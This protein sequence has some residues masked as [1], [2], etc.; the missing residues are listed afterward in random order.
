MILRDTGVCLLLFIA[1]I[2]MPTTAFCGY[3]VDHSSGFPNVSY[4]YVNGEVDSAYAECERFRAAHE[5]PLAPPQSECK[6]FPTGA[7]A[8]GFATRTFCTTVK[9][10]WG[11]WQCD[12]TVGIKHAVFVANLC[13][14]GSGYSQV[15][16]GCVPI[17]LDWKD[18]PQHCPKIG[19]P[20]S[21]LQ[22]SK[23]LSQDLGIS[24]DNLAL[25]IIYNTRSLQAITPSNPSEPSA[26]F[27][28]SIK[29]DSV[30]GAGW[31]INSHATIQWSTQ[32]AAIDSGDGYLQFFSVTSSGLKPSLKTDPTSPCGQYCNE[33]IHR[34]TEGAYEAYNVS[35]G[36]ERYAIR[37]KVFSNGRSLNYFYSTSS[38][39]SSV[40]P[41]PNLL[42]RVVDTFGRTISFTYQKIGADIRLASIMGP[43]GGKVL[44]GYDSTA[45]LISITRPDMSVRSFLYEQEALPGFLTGVVDENGGRYAS[46]SYDESTGNAISTMLGDGKSRFSVGYQSGP[47]WESSDVYDPAAS[48]IRRTIALKP[49]EGVL[50]TYPSGRVET[51]ISATA[52]GVLKLGLQTQ[53]PGAGCA[54]SSAESGYD[55]NGFLSWTES[56]RKYRTCFSYDSASKLENIRVEGLPSNTDCSGVLAPNSPLPAGARKITTERDSRSGL[57]TRI[58]EPK[59]VTTLVY[60][61]KRD[62]LGTPYSY[63]CAPTNATQPN[64]D[65]I[66]VLCIKREQVTLD[67]DGRAGPAALLDGAALMRVNNWTYNE[68]GQVLS[69]SDALNNATTYTYHPSNT[70]NFARGDLATVKNALN[71]VTSFTK[72]SQSGQWLEMID[73]NG[74]TTTRTFDLRQRLRTT[75]TAGLTTQY[76]YWPTGLLKTVT[77]PDASAVNYGYDDAHRLTSVTDNRGN[78]ITYTLDNSGN[79]IGEAIT[80][81]SGRLAKTL[82]RVPDALNRIQQVTGRE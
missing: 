50:V 15:A 30:L 57:A 24:I 39:P 32:S 25:R 52:D 78:K 82:T 36:E 77:L 70:E 65:G 38:T 33:Y 47:K 22:G 60:N 40:A 68:Y 42:L 51:P 28:N 13:A 35:L 61:S 11:Q 17:V 5:H 63:W 71:Q 81:P 76:D 74:I 79:R 44:L 2:F 16:N 23:Y 20:I 80:D 53:A 21:P 12:P 27:K 14:T 72:Y 9:F 41:G 29:R 49:P 55:A 48:V 6:N 43:D 46:Y 8:T 66:G 3:L 45:Q 1:G 75:T 59:K 4:Y 19:Q 26:N 54:A 18:S 10:L 37:A 69:H 7:N 62:P 34:P 64:H 58:F 56:L 73:A 67:V 31:G